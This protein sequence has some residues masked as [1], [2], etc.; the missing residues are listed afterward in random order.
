MFRCLE[1]VWNWRC[2]TGREAIGLSLLKSAEGST[3]A[4]IEIATDG[5]T[6]PDACLG[7]ESFVAITVANDLIS[8][9]GACDVTTK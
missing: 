5:L 9:A 2:L 8:E 6:L 4:R 3:K 7:Y 1:F